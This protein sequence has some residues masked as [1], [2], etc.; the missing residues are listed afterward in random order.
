MP[1]IWATDGAR[2]L[3]KIKVSASIVLMVERRRRNWQLLQY[4]AGVNLDALTALHAEDLADLQSRYDQAMAARESSMD[5]IAR[6]MSELAASTTAQPV[7][8]FGGGFGGFGAGAP[9]PAAAP[10][11]QAEGQPIVRLDPADV[12]KCTDCKNCWQ[13]IPELF[14]R[15]KVIVDGQA[16]IAARLI[17]GALDKVE[18]TDDLQRRIAK[19]VANCDAEIIHN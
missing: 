10:A 5:E 18:V 11:E 2:R 4:L 8:T 15:T 3:V 17:P 9:A 19:V 13:E 14:E 6:A 16:K 1:F 7:T 12:P